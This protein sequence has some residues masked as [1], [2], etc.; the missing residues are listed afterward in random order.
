[1]KNYKCDKCLKNF[2][3]KKDHLIRH[4]N[5][6]KACDLQLKLIYNTIHP[7]ISNLKRKGGVYAIKTCLENLKYPDFCTLRIGH[8]KNIKKRFST[9]NTSIQDDE[10]KVE[11]N[12]NFI[13]HSEISAFDGTGL[14]ESITH[15][16]FNEYRTKKEFFRFEK[17]F[18]IEDYFESLEYQFQLCNINDLKIYHSLHDTPYTILPEN[19]SIIKE[20]IDEQLTPRE[21]QVEII[22]NTVQYFLKNNNGGLFLPPGYGKTYISIISLQQLNIKKCLILTHRLSITREWEKCLTCAKIPFVVVNSENEYN[23]SSFAKIDKLYIIS[24]YQTYIKKSNEFEKSYPLIIHDESHVLIPNIQIL[25]DEEEKEEENKSTN[26]SKCLQLVGKKLF[27]TATPTIHSYR[28]DFEERITEELDEKIYGK[29]IAHVSL[30]DAVEQGCLCG[31]RIL[32]YNKP[33]TVDCFE[34]IDDLYTKYGRKK[35]LLFYN[36]CEDAKKASEHLR[37]NNVN[38]WYLDGYTSKKLREQIFTDFQNCDKGVIVN[39]NIMTEG[40][41]IE[42]VDCILLMDKRNSMRVLIQI[43][44]RSLRL[45]KGKICSLFC[46]PTDCSDTLEMS[47]TALVYDSKNGN[48]IRKNIITNAETIKER[49]E[50]VSVIYKKLQWVELT[51]NGISGMV[52]YKIQRLSEI[53]EENKKLVETKFITEDGIK[54]GNFQNDL[55]CVVSGSM[56]RFKKEIDGWKEKYPYL[57]ELIN[58]RAKNAINNRKSRTIPMNVK[59][60]RLSE[61]VEENKSLV[62][63]KFIT[64]DRMK[65]GL[66]QNHLICT[67]SGSRQRFKKEIDGWKKKYPYLFELINERAKNNIDTRKSR[68]IPASVKIERLNEIVKDQKKLV[69]YKFITEDGMKL[70]NFQNDLIFI[71]SRSRQRFKKEID[72]WREKYPY[73]FKLIDDRILN[74]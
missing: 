6:K 62:E 39:V 23:L 14:L 35:I 70:G 49:D 44:G 30:E 12:L 5:N 8:S 65:L 53:V 32:A 71:I 13:L 73:L 57:F 11:N 64:D 24:T 55:I 33:S 17:D 61:C 31:Y 72:G 4:Q 7:K 51:R 1:M 20:T 74:R 34:H 58:E 59:I 46:I 9:Y 3:N 2:G 63:V 60:Q 45:Y 27:L 15:W 29:T 66:F 54:L 47:L 21:Y 26:F 40:V 67:V 43:L 50:I 56:Q 19:Y 41:S 28:N 42:C 10:D 38:V 36:R 25:E 68:T 37:K 18:T 52:N 48:K 16:H 69:E 22:A